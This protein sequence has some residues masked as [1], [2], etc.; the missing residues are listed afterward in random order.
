MLKKTIKNK[1]RKRNGNWHL[2]LILTVQLY[3]IAAHFIG[4]IFNYTVIDQ[5]NSKITFDMI[6][7]CQNTLSFLHLFLIWTDY[8]HS[9][10]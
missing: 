9:N 8:R 2:F 1:K 5:F 6:P 7:Y 10:Y 4:D 3:Q